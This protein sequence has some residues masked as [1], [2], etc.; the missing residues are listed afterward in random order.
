MGSV[1]GA[2][3]PQKGQ[4]EALKALY[5]LQEKDLELDRLKEEAEALPQEL[6]SVRTQVEA[7][8]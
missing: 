2:D 5:G 3:A 6:L 8:E 4:L 1:N 7:L